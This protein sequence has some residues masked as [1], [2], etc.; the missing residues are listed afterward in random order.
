MSV[1]TAERMAVRLEVSIK[2]IDRRVTVPTSGSSTSY[3]FP[4]SCRIQLITVGRNV[5]LLAQLL[6]QRLVVHIERF[7]ILLERHQTPGNR[8]ACFIH[9]K[10]VVLHFQIR[11]KESPGIGKILVITTV[12]PL[13]LRV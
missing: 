8:L 12:E 3:I 2:P 7:K 5:E 1:Q 4:L 13:C 11:R 10:K 9:G 6:V